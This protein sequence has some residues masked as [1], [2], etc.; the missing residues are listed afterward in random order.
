[1]VGRERAYVE[2]CGAAVRRMAADAL[3]RGMKGLNQ[4]DAGG[5]LQVGGG[6]R[7]VWW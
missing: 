5:A 7:G 6:E 3:A 2:T 4:T 1:M